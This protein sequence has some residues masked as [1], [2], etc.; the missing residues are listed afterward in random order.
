[1][2]VSSLKNFST[3]LKMLSS[4]NKVVFAVFGVLAIVIFLM[5]MVD[6]SSI[7]RVERFEE[8][9]DNE[10]DIDEQEVVK[11][12]KNTHKT[13]GKHTNKPT[14][15]QL[16][17]EE[18][19][20]KP[21]I[22]EDRETYN[23]E[24]EDTIEEQPTKQANDIVSYVSSLVSNMNIPSS[25]KVDTFKELFNGNNANQLHNLTTTE[26]AKK[27]VDK[28]MSSLGYTQET[29]DDDVIKSIQDT[30]KDIS[31]LNT[32]LNNLLNDYKSSKTT[33]KPQVSIPRQSNQSNTNK[34][35]TP[36]SNRIT[37]PKTNTAMTDNSSLGD[38]IEGF[39]NLRHNFATYQ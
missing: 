3:K 15:T 37:P 34:T 7:P 14:N 8:N 11:P 33:H 39:E 1:M 16:N 28:V 26:Q 4:K 38:V 24:L 5:Y 10:D 9:E 27:F 25:L 2:F 18:L 12:L 6:N 31:D 19:K 23:N 36:M 13:N 21:T 35:L 20:E 30:Q 22:P 29:F 17:Q 32:K